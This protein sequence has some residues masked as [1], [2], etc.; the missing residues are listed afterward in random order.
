MG[1]T[2]ILLQPS[3]DRTRKPLPTWV[4]L[5][6]GSVALA[7][8]IAL[9]PYVSPDSRLFFVPWMQEFRTQG[10]SALGG[11]FSSYNF[12]YMF[13]MFLGSLIPAE[14][15]YAVKIVS[16]VGD[17]LLAF[18]VRGVVKQL[19]SAGLRP[20]VAALIALFLPTVLLNA[21]MWGQ[22]DSIYTAFLLLSLR[23]LLLRDGPRAWLWWAVALSFKLQAVFFLPALALIALRNRHSLAL[24]AMAV[25]VWGLFS[26]LPILF[27]RTLTS[28]FSVYFHQ[29]QEDN[30]SMG[31]VNIYAWFPSVTAAEGKIPALLICGLGLLVM[32]TAYWRGPD[33]A[34]RNVLL[35]ISSVALC[36]FLLPQMHDR[37]FFTAEVMS[38]L[39]LHRKKLR[40]VPWL[41]AG[42]GLVAYCLYFTGYRYI[43]PLLLASIVQFFA[44][45]A[46]VFELWR[47]NAKHQKDPLTPQSTANS[48]ASSTRTT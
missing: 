30:L 12:P 9:F 35:A 44:I 41:L 4:L 21:S 23:S 39:L 8:R 38:L 2:E 18:S 40:L 11:E 19:P 31:A 7:A 15:H 27:G 42:T 32:A 13:L 43:W 16:L 20:E 28:T 37:Y 1:G 5:I 47:T 34:D 17:C 46:V 33:S 14:E 22:C 48:R 10:A 6:L 45:A 36:P 3:T 24:P 25:G 29:T 26:G